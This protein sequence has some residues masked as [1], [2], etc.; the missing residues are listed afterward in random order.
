MNSNVKQDSEAKMILE[1]RV[2]RDKSVMTR[3]E[4]ADWI[5]EHLFK[6]TF[7]SKT[8][9]KRA[10]LE[11]VDKG[12][13]ALC[14]HGIFSFDGIKYFT[15]SHSKAIETSFTGMR[16]QDPSNEMIFASEMVEQL[17][18]RKGM[19][20]LILYLQE[21]GSTSSL[22]LYRWYLHNMNPTMQSK[23]FTNVLGALGDGVVLERIDGKIR[24][25]K[26]MGIEIAKGL[27]KYR[28]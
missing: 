17:K 10:A 25:K 20:N 19:C 28:F 18:V 27:A 13:S 3:D 24:L 15:Y 8:V 1:S 16:N 2:I 14:Y 4:L 23:S 11:V 9:V 21:V 6:R 7:G 26:T 5:C 22:E 12:T